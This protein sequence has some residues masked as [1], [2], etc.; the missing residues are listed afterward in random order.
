MLPPGEAIVQGRP[1]ALPSSLQPL[2]DES[3]AGFLLRLAHRLETTPARILE[4]AGFAGPQG[5]PHASGIPHHAML[6]LTPRQRDGLAR[7]TRLAPQEA[8]ALCFGQMRERFPL[9][10]PRASGQAPAKRFDWWLNTTFSRY[11]PQ[12]LA[13]D[14]TAIQDEHG[15]AWKRA[16]RLP[17]AFACE[18][19]NRLL[20]HRCPACGHPALG[21]HGNVGGTLVPGMMHRGLHP[22]Q[23]RADSRTARCGQRL[24]D[25]ADPEVPTAELLEL[26]QRLTSLLL[27]DGPA[28]VMSAGEPCS[29]RQYFTDLR[30]VSYLAITTWPGTRHLAPGSRLAESVD[31]LAAHRGPDGERLPRSPAA[32]AR[33][34]DASAAACLLWTAEQLLTGDEAAVREAVRALLP[35]TID[36]ASRAGWRLT[37]LKA[38]E[39]AYSPG[40]SAAVRPVLSRDR[41][42]PARGRRR[43]PELRYRF[44][45]DHVPQRLPEEWLQR[46]FGTSAAAVPMDALQRATTIRLV[47]MLAGG[48]KDD[49]AVYLGFPK[50]ARHRQILATLPATAG[51]TPARRAEDQFDE[52]VQA[53]ARELASGKLTDYRSRRVALFTWELEQEDWQSLVARARARTDGSRLALGP[54]DDVDRLA[55]SVA[56]WQRATHGF[57]RY[58]PLLKTAPAADRCRR[59]NRV[60]WKIMVGRGSSPVGIELHR[61]LNDYADQ[62]SCRID[63]GLD[64]RANSPALA[65]ETPRSRPP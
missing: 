43:Q 50:A 31:Q 63:A 12:C 22:A 1:A 48:S 3:L 40:L 62:L 44:G 52:L 57:Y 17:V 56:I 34:A 13:G 24:D 53:I 14:G 26:Q 19:H 54:H 58:A 64:S 42:I 46:H 25:P 37:F 7:A 32:L 49:A 41:W 4:L 47:Q 28:V 23:C 30:L 35:A 10:Q 60:T 15:G 33:P 6:E 65:G 27:P 2:P 38:D 59:E 20:A 45:P 18:A 61:L 55:A 29:P 9:P 11:C 21:T 8:E 51:L 5:W 16:W 39:A 36:R